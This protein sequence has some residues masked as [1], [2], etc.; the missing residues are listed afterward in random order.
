MDGRLGEAPGRA[1]GSGLLIATDIETHRAFERFARWTIEQERPSAAAFLSGDELA[2]FLDYYRALPAPDDAR[3]IA[4]YVRGLWRGE[5]GW[6]ARWI[7]AARARDGRAPRV[8]DAG[9]GYGTFSLLFAAVG[10]D[11][12][13]ADLRPD[14]LAVAERR[15]AYH[16]SSTGPALCARFERRDLAHDWGESFDVVWVYNALSHIDPL[17]P[18]LER[19]ARHLT[20]GGVLVVGDI[21][22]DNPA[23]RRR[24]GGL[25]TEVHQEYVAPDGRRYAYAI[26]RLLSPA[27]LRAAVGAQGLTPVHH[28]LYWLGLARAPEPVHAALIAPLQ[29]RLAFGR[30]LARRQLFVAQKPAGAAVSAGPRASEG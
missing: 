26:E 10:A 18:F 25:R 12:I 28:E 1:P 2:G 5:A 17:E 24:V 30:L 22:G 20:P 7:A 8:L 6:A 9:C 11:V 15:R 21:N 19:V 3:G 27:A 16:A 23:H 4:H 14:R 13:G 29:R